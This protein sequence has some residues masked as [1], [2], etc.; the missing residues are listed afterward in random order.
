MPNASYFAFRATPQ[1]KTLEF[2]GEAF[3]A[4]GQTK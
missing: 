1:N 2:F 3:P 4:D